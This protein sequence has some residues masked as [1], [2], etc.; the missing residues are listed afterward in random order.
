MAPVA[1][2][3]DRLT[4]TGVARLW[5]QDRTSLAICRARHGALVDHIRA[6]ENAEIK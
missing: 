4:A 6:Q 1:F 3:N 2:S 5:G